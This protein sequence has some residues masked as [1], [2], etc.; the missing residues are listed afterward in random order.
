MNNSSNIRK[1]YIKSLIRNEEIED[2]ET[3]VNLLETKFNLETNQ[4]VISR[5]LKELK[6]HK[7]SI[8]KKYIYE[9]PQDNAKKEIIKLSINTI[10]H[11]E[12]L[13][14]VN[15]APGI[16]D[17]IGDYLDEHKELGILGT[18]AGETVVFI[19]PKSISH[20]KQTYKDICKILCW[21][22]N[23]N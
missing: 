19:T 1:K 16:A 5:D 6:I 20:I 13:I 2:Q 21:E 4:A 15:C 22:N 3:L 17:V 8:G 18:L 14:I 12:Y 23:E 11:N 7:R 10:V 9:L